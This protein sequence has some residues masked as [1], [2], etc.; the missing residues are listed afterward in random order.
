MVYPITKHLRRSLKGF[1]ERLWVRTW[2]DGT[3]FVGIRH[4]Y[5]GNESPYYAALKAKCEELG[6]TVCNEGKPG[7]VG[8][9]SFQVVERPI[10]F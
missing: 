1:H 8:E 7:T 3:T 4:L 2:K 6:Y 10:K 9:G 5:K